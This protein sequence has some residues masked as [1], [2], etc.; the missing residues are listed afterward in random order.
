MIC[1]CGAE[2]TRLEIT[3]YEE[4]VCN[5]CCRCVLFTED[6]TIWGMHRQYPGLEE[7]EDNDDRPQQD[8]I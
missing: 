5:V 4:Y 6:F 3:I 2:M 7:Q 1:R 8:H